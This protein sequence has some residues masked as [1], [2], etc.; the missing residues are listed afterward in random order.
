MRAVLAEEVAGEDFEFGD[1]VVGVGGVGEHGVGEVFFVAGIEVSLIEA[2]AP[3]YDGHSVNL[4]I[5][6]SPSEFDVMVP[7]DQ[8]GLTTD[9]IPYNIWKT[10]TSGSDETGTLRLSLHLVEEFL[11]V[12]LAIQ[13]SQDLLAFIV[14]EPC[15]LIARHF[16]DLVID[17][18]RRRFFIFFVC[19]IDGFL[20]QNTGTGCLKV[21][22]NLGILWQSF[23]L[24]LHTLAPSNEGQTRVV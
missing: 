22:T 6:S 1:E 23:E 4:H 13:S 5:S 16:V 7:L 9:V 2:G 19:E 12:N 8:C 11:F 20:D 17:F 15:G 10:L 24:D 3:E 14:A 21:G 18:K